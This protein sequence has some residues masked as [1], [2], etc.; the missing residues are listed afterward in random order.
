MSGA[1]AELRLGVLSLAV[2]VPTPL[3]LSEEYFHEKSADLDP[4]DTGSTG[5]THCEV[6]CHKS[7]PGVW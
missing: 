5:L 1:G 7:D 3:G 6:K 2:P 4:S